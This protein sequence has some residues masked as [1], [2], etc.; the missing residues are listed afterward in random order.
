MNP[1]PPSKLLFLCS[2]NY[3][4]SRFAEIYFNHLAR[5]TGLK[6]RA[7]S[8]GLKHTWSGNPGPMA[9]SAAV[10]LFRKG[11]L[12]WQ[13]LR[14]PVRAI[15]NDFNQSGM[16]IA[17]K[18]SEHRPYMRDH[19]NQWT[20]TIHYWQIHDVDVDPPSKTLPTLEAQIEGL[21]DQL[22]SGSK[23]HSLN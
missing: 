20:E 11:I 7:Y 3:Y 6:W 8:R 5:K 18:E 19:F 1:N 17:L 15:E 2:G 10:R 16:V 21:V 14:F 22:Q 9:P 13:Y 12:S 4:R 23:V